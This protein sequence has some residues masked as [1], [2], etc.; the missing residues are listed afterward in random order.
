MHLDSL[1][2]FGHTIYLQRNGCSR[3]DKQPRLPW[4]SAASALYPIV[5]DAAEDAS[6]PAYSDP[7]HDAPRC[8]I[9]LFQRGGNAGEERNPSGSRDSAV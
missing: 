6:T 2:A 9:L 8:L 1:V 4:P 5:V 3:L 7:P